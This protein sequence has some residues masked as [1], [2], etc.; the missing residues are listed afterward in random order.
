MV[1]AAPPEHGSQSLDR[2]SVLSM[3]NVSRETAA[4]LDR[5]VALLE[6]WQKRINL[7]GRG[8]TDDIWGRH[9]AD[10]LQLI[11]LVP[12]RSRIWLDLGSG[13]G[14]PGLVLAIALK[15]RPDLAVHLV[16]SNAK[17]SAFLR[18][19][20]GS[21]A[22]PAI[23]HHCRIEDLAN[24]SERP[25]PDVI[26][27]RA[28]APLHDL[29]RLAYPFMGKTTQCLFPKGQ[30]MARELTDCATSWTL[31]SEAH[32]SRVDPVASI[33]RIEEMRRHDARNRNGFP[34]KRH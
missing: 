1:C 10:S 30:D 29:L 5:Y 33:L 16:E 15:D 13:A 2:D 11:D 28:L 8:T 3:F 24:D 34:A 9:I 31:S 27:A 17:K 23:V 25:Y 21:C 18:V 22:V 32:T 12:E 14:L 20:A 26:V 6:Q 4:L 19:A 7:I